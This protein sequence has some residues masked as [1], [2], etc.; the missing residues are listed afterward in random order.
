[1]TVQSDRV[2]RRRRRRLVE[3]RH[4]RGTRLSHSTGTTTK[5]TI[6]SDKT[7]LLHEKANLEAL[8]QGHLESA[9]DYRL[10]ADQLRRNRDRPSDPTRALEHQR[11]TDRRADQAMRDADRADREAENTLN[12]IRGL[13]RSIRDAS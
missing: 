4:G 5:E 8:R 7:R 1:V 9:R 6:V 11:D 12:A 13:E 10:Q 3:W 2:G